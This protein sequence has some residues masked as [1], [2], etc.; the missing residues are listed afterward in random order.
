MTPSDASYIFTPAERA[1]CS[2]LIVEPE[3]TE[4]N[5][6]RVTLKDLGFGSVAESPHHLA[7]LE[8]FDGRKFTHIIFDAKKGNYPVKDWFLKVLEIAPNITAI[9]ASAN[10]NIDDVFDL[11]LAG[12]RGYLVKPF[13]RDTLDVAV[14]MA[15]K[16]EPI[17]DV[18]KQAR[19]RNEALVAI[20][21][22]S[23]DRLAVVHRQSRQFE[24]AL[25]ELPRAEAALRR[26]SDLALTF[27]KGGENGLI[28]A[29]EAFCVNKSRG[30]ATRLGRLR[31]RLSTTRVNDEALPE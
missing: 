24:T 27:A 17:P 25:R 1:L 28:H 7:S 11:L 14:A 30:P 9:P 26:A 3:P 29:L 16:G 6:L 18:V 21:M 8:K 19:N 13:T 23:L 15:T 2:I 4:R 22:S 20:M 5:L 12:A 31:K 10:P